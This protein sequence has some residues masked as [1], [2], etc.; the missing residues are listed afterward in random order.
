M[1]I[2]KLT[3]ENSNL[4]NCKLIDIMSFSE[5]SLNNIE[6]SNNNL[7]ITTILSSE[8]SNSLKRIKIENIRLNQDKISGSTYFNLIDPDYIKKPSFL[9]KDLNLKSCI[10]DGHQI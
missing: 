4:D 7:K 10:I 3:L 6:M 2:N 5:I 1:I 9:I 8:S